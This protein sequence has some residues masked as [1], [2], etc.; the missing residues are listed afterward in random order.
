M[1][2]VHQ[3]SCAKPALGG[4]LCSSVQFLHGVFL[5]LSFD[6]VFLFL[7]LA[8]AAEEQGADSVARTFLFVVAMGAFTFVVSYVKLPP[9]PSKTKLSARYKIQRGRNILVLK[10]SVYFLSYFIR[11]YGSGNLLTLSYDYW[12]F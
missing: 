4:T 10:C 7:L 8:G 2:S 6:V 1:R 12:Q 9:L 11:L 5:A 3:I